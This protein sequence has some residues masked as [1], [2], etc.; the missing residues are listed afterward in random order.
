M[1]LPLQAAPVGRGIARAH[2]AQSATQQGCDWLKCAEAGI[3]CV[4]ACVPN[5]LS[6]GCIACLGPL[7][8]TCKDCFQP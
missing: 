3:G 8:D 4:A 1:N 5:P 7:W 6:P 2:Q